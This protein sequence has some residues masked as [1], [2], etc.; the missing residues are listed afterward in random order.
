MP[1][2]KGSRGSLRLGVIA[3][4]APASQAGRARLWSQQC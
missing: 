4:V 1:R 3:V 2:R